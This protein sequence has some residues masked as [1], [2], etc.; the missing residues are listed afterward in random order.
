MDPH[1]QA[2]YLERVTQEFANELDRI[3]TAD[4]FRPDSVPV[5]VAALQQG[6]ALYSPEQQARIV[7][8]QDET[9]KVV[10][11]ADASDAFS[12]DGSETS[13]SRSSEAS[14]GSSS[15]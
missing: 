12:S 6:A 4:D 11:T 15:S 2:I 7:G 8:R 3:R 5:L 13:S 14:S 1:F 9:D 10:D